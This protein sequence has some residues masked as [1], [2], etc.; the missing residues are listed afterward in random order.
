MS[1]EESSIIHWPWCPA[2]LW[3]APRFLWHRGP[4]KPP[5]F[6]SQGSW[7]HCYA[8]RFPMS[9]SSTGVLPSV[10]WPSQA[11]LKDTPLS[12]LPLSGRVLC[13]A[14]KTS[15]LSD[16]PPQAPTPPLTR[17]VCQLQS[18]PSLNKCVR[19]TQY[20]LGTILKVR[21]RGT[22]VAHFSETSDS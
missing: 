10:T 19:N 21:D 7:H 13:T 22:W 3:A 4:G 5:V 12:C 15:M 17:L 2:L 16:Q 14:P 20:V 1:C 6:S 18:L 9:E 8:G 11:G